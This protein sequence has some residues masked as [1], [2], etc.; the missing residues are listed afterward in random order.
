MK[1]INEVASADIIEMNDF[2]IAL[3]EIK[4]DFGHDVDKRT[5]DTL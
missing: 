4:T 3:S 1:L 2:P 5:Y